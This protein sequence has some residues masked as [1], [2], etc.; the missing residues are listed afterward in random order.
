MDIESGIDRFNKV[1][2]NNRFIDKSNIETILYGDFISILNN[3]FIY[4]KNKV[5]LCFDT[6]NNDYSITLNVKIDRIKNIGILPN[7]Y[8]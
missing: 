5:K 2:I 8:Y 7:N 4:D 1:L 3:Y 6:S